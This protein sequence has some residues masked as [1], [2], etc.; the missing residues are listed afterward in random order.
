MREDVAHADATCFDRGGQQKDFARSLLGRTLCLW[1]MCLFMSVASCIGFGLWLRAH[2]TDGD[3]LI[4]IMMILM[5]SDQ[6]VTIA[7]EPQPQNHV[8]TD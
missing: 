8:L 4:V 7:S 2:H 1:L 3:L 6:W 5:R